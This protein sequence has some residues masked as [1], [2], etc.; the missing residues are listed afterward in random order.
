MII[1]RFAMHLTHQEERF[2]FVSVCTF[3]RTRRADAEY[4]I[5]LGKDEA[6]IDAIVDR[7]GQ[8]VGM[9]YD[10]TC[11]PANGCFNFELPE[12]VIKLIKVQ[13]P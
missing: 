13:N 1:R 8:R 4:G 2:M 9:V 7:T 3:K 5:A 11:Y 10:Y 12:V 6:A